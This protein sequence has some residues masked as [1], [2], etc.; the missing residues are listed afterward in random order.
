MKRLGLTRVEKIAIVVGS[1]ALLIVLIP[2]YAT[3]L[4]DKRTSDCLS[5][6]K[7]ISNAL[8][9]YQLD[10]ENS[11]PPAYYAAGDGQPLLDEANRPITWIAPVAAYLKKSPD[12]VFKCPGDP[13]GGSTI[14][15][16][17]KDSSRT[18]QLSYGFYAPLSGKS[19][20]DLASPGQ[21]VLIA[22]SL[23]GGRNGSMNPNPMLDG[24][25]GFLLAA[26]D[27]NGAPG[28]QSQY[29]ARLAVWRIDTNKGWV[30]DNLRAFH[31]RGVN[32]LMAD[33]HITTR[34]PGIVKLERDEQGK[35]QPPW[36]LPEPRAR[37]AFSSVFGR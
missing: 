15:S 34:S 26:E 10:Y 13:F 6:L 24:N 20:E 9:V 3:L 17:P 36:L 12:V 37:G 35:V 5:H 2:F 18:L 11:W 8:S 1:L 30:A 33:G 19:I 14:V 28:S 25:D 16:D 31:G 32:V 23:A 27:T 22:D 21:S 4:D 7:E 29:V